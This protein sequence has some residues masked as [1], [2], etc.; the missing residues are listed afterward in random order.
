MTREQRKLISKSPGGPLITSWRANTPRSQVNLH[1]FHLKKN[2]RSETR[3]EASTSGR[4]KSIAHATDCCTSSTSTFTSTLPSP[5]A[6]NTKRRKKEI[7]ESDSEDIDNNL[8]IQESSDSEINFSESEEVDHVH[9]ELWKSV[10]RI[11][12]E[13]VV[14]IYVFRSRTWHEMVRVNFEKTHLC[15]KFS[16]TDL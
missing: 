9:K 16:L 13:L 6:S 4:R 11:C 7:V 5:S 1:C 15:L 2:C 8:T 14:F 12:G 3:Q 10:Q